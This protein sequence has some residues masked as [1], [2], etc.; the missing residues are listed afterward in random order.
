MR[1]SSS[2]GRLFLFSVVLMAALPGGAHGE[3]NNPADS[4][5]ATSKR[6]LKV[7][8][9]AP[10]WAQLE[11][12]DGKKHS[13]KDLRD[14]K[15]IAVVFTTNHCPVAV[16][17][18]D[19][20]VELHN[21][22]KDKGVALVAINVNNIEADRLP[23]MKER[24]EEKGF[25]FAYLY[26]PSQKIGRAFG[27]T[28]TPHAFLL[29]GDRKLVYMGAVDDNQNSSEVSKHYLQDAIEAVLAGRAPEPA[30]TK[31]FGCGIQYE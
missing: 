2:V 7:G 30:T 31:Q 16:A 18:E 26:D 8:D 13:L 22:Y 1:K 6:S 4:A 9:P 10:A 21:K 27:A 25:E 24:A 28:V 23:K 5:A 17:Y 14:A 29:D 3:A 15:A 19:R 20:L 12:V 11:G